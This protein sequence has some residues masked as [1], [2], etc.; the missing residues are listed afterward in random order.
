MQ[1]NIKAIKA[2]NNHNYFNILIYL[3]DICNFNCS[4]CY[5]K[6]P[7]SNHKLNIDTL[8]N[9]LFK[10]KQNIKTNLHLELIGGEP[11]LHPNLNQ[12]INNIKPITNNILI[13]T[14]L[15]NNISIY[16]NLLDN[17]INLFATWHNQNNNF[18]DNLNQLY[19]HKH[20]IDI[21]IMY[22]HNNIDKSI[23]IYNQIKNLNFKTHALTLVDSNDQSYSKQDIGK[24]Q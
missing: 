23:S 3:C 6:K 17:N 11:T 12:F 16:K 1:S 9:F 5:N 8:T 14:N 13:Y 20:L 15:S 24:I 7:R 18:I 22:E 19:N 10:I 4:Y 2:I 21:S